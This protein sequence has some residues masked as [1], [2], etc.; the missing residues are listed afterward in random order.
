VSDI[1]NFQLKNLPAKVN[2]TET[3]VV[4]EGY[5]GQNFKTNPSPDQM[6]TEFTKVLEMWDLG[7]ANLAKLGI[8]EIVFCLPYYN[9]Q[10]NQPKIVLDLVTKHG[11]LIQNY[12]HNPNHQSNKP[13]FLDII[14]TRQTSRVGHWIFKLS[15]RN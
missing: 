15:R 12:L 1:T 8:P 2:W 4:T 7:L 6:L 3:S 14:Y 13:I 9:R 5:L 11:Y 10:I